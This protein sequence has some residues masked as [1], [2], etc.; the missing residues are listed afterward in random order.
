MY[1][2]IF[3][4]TTAFTFIVSLAI[5]VGPTCHYRKSP[6]FCQPDELI[7]GADENLKLTNL[8]EL[9]LNSLVTWNQRT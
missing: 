2:Q 3:V 8:R 9:N 4:V 5:I 1:L 6:K 7:F